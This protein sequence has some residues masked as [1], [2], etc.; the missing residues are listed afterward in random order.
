[1]GELIAG[2]EFDSYKELCEFSGIKYDVHTSFLISR[3]NKVCN[4]HIENKKIIVDDVFGKISDIKYHNY[5][6]LYK[7]DD[8]VKTSSGKI[9]IIKQ[10]RIYRNNRAYDYICLKDGY[11]GTISEEHLKHGVGCP[12]CSGKICVSE[13]NSIYATRKDLLKFIA[14]EDDAYR[15]TVCSGKKILCKCPLCGYKK[16][17]AIN[18]LSGHGF[19]CNFCADGLSYPNKFIYSFLNQLKVD[20]TPEKIF[21]WCT[22][23]IYDIYI[24]SLN[25]IIENHGKQHYI[26]SFERCGGRT[27]EEEKENDLFKYHIALEN[28]IS[29][30]IVIDC[31][32]SNLDYIKNSIMCSDLP[33]LLHFTEKDIDWKS[34]HKYALNPIIKEVCEYWETHYKNIT[35]T[36]EFFKLDIH[37]V[38]EYLEKGAKIGY[39]SYKKGFSDSRSLSNIQHASK[40]IYNIENDI[41]FFS[42]HECEKYFKEN[43]SDQTFN[44]N[45]LYAY[46]NKSK[47][48]HN[49]TFVYVDKY[50]YNEQK[51]LYENGKS[52]HTVIGNYYLERYI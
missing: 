24:P 32:E 39:C 40:P 19:S 4:F 18:N 15:Y 41:Y 37:T 10:S 7:I 13:I 1:M 21:D 25:I 47:K 30:Y 20:Y 36:K 28:N 22:N 33:E 23:K 12:V 9:K 42:K 29:H 38:M 46:I 3:I 31:R 35:C 48:Y 14:N 50:K 27:L 17:M 26:R 45:A 2:M 5:K 51:K 16:K 52:T 43:Y 49:N 44:G 34:C 8:I 11:K 6:Y